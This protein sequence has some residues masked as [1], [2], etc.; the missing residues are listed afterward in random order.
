MLLRL[1]YYAMLREWVLTHNC[2]GLWQ[3]EHSIAYYFRDHE[4]GNNLKNGSALVESSR[5]Q[6]TGETCQLIV[7]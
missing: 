1:G 2:H 5:E 6:L 7:L 3:G 4:H